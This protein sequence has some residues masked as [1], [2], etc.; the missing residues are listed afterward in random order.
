M[1]AS[2]SKKPHLAVHTLA[3]KLRLKRRKVEHLRGT[4]RLLQAECE[5]LEAEIRRRGV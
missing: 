5:R 3:A 4:L 2:P 1:K